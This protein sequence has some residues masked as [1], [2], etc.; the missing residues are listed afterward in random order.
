LITPE[1]NKRFPLFARLSTAQANTWE[2]ATP[3]TQLFPSGFLT[4][5]IAFDSL[6]NSSECD[7]DS[8]RSRAA[9]WADRIAYSAG[10][11]FQDLDRMVLL[12]VNDF[13]SQALLDSEPVVHAIGCKDPPCI[14]KASA[15]YGEQAHRPAPKNSDGL[16]W[17][18]FASSAVQ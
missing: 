9:L 16:A 12:E 18:D 3:G 14:Q 11:L 13:R 8:F 10:K 17:F 4:G 7:L 5:A 15:C 1:L 6:L 2:S